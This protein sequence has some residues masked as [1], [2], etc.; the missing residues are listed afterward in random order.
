MDHSARPEPGD[1]TTA[2]VGPSVREHM[3][4]AVEAMSWR[5]RGARE[6]YIHENLGWNT[7][8]HAQVVNALIDRPDVV[9]AYPMLTARLRR[10]R[11]RRLAGRTAP[12][13][14]DGH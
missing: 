10:L 6:D 13:T 14:L 11:Q 3:T 8:R 7:I 1:A 9:A 2:L 5:S 12:A 4:L